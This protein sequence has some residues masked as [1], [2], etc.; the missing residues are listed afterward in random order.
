MDPVSLAL[1][2]SVLKVVGETIKKLKPSLKGKGEHPPQFIKLRVAGSE[3]QLNPCEAS[4]ETI[5]RLMNLL[6]S[7]EQAPQAP[8]DVLSLSREATNTDQRPVPSSP[9]RTELGAAAL[10]IS[11]D[12]V[13]GDARHRMSLVFKLNLAIAITLAIILFGGLGGAVYSAVFV[14]NNIWATVFGGISAADVIGLLVFKPL[15]AINSALIG[16]QRLEMLH[17]R[18]RQQLDLCAQHKRLHERIQC[19]TLVW[20]SIQ[21][22]LAALAGTVAPPS[23]SRT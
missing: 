16:T 4:P 1:A 17:L 15:T 21:Q 10:A 19:Q 7:L 6:K 20:E 13:F 2:T 5:Y 9:E 23:T 8:S 14:G 12:A 22:D 18:L 3:I 11:P